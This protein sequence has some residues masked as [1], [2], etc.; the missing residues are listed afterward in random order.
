MKKSGGLTRRE[1][2]KLISLAPVGIFSRPLSGWTG[3]LNPDL[4][5]IIIIV[6]DA[7][8]QQHV[9]LYG[10]PRQTM[11]NLEKFAERATVYHNHYSAGTF[12]SPGTASILTGLYSWSHRAL[13]LGAVPVPAHATHNI[14]AAL[15]ATHTTLG[16]AQNEFADQVLYGMRNAVETHLENWIFSAQNSNL[17][18]APIFKNNPRIAFAGIEDLMIRRIE[19]YDASL[20]LGPYLRLQFL[21]NRAAFAIRHGGDYPRGLPDS[22]ELFLLE[23]V[24]DGAIQALREVQSPMLAYFHFYPP[25]DPYCP[26]KGFYKTFI[27]G[28]APPRK[29]I[30]DLSEYK[31]SAGRLDSNRRYYDEYLAS[32]DHETGRLFDFLEESGLLENSYIFITSDHG[33]MFERG[34]TGHF[35]KLM[36]DPLIRVPLIV[37]RPDQTTREDVHALTSSVDIMPTVANVLGLAIP[38][39]VE[40]TALPGLGG[41]DHGERRSIFTLDA[42]FNSSFAPLRDYSLA[43]TRDGHRLVHYSY[44]KDNYEK[45]EFYD[46]HADPH[47]L[48]DL[49]PSEPAL[50][51]E[52]RDEVLQK[53]EEVNRPYRR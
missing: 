7:W 14:F 41:V 34:I 45:Y 43:L 16:Y 4:P 9:S 32:W 51:I 37:S 6:F 15:S 25:H 39:W 40:G 11:P 29:P 49:C 27:D 35:T 44:P 18:S 21:R 47:E 1:F 33:E 50:S 46:L 36:Y 20:F 30:H 8:S 26:T 31:Y 53:I 48:N 23:D 22:S 13:H 38:T 52:M 10:Y 5:N 28:W 19:G 42:K 2:L 3:S 24:V 17:Y 12:T